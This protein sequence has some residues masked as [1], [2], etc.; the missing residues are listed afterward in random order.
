MEISLLRRRDGTSD[1]T[2]SSHKIS[3]G[4]GCGSKRVQWT[5]H[6]LLVLLTL[7]GVFQSSGFVQINVPRI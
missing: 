2:G 5:S 1:L 3:V 6:S 4:T 7:T